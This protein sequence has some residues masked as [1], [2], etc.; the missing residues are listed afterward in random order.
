MPCIELDSC[1]VEIQADGTISY[2]ARASLNESLQSG[3]AT[4]TWFIGGE[5]AAA[6][7]PL[8]FSGTQATIAS[9]PSRN[10]N[11]VVF[12]STESELRQILGSGD[13]QVQI[14]FSN[15]D[16]PTC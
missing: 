3:S 16:F 11:A 10:P 1:N 13:H 15:S 12:I 8:F 14:E 7:D 6:I 9:A 4:L 5:R 2:E